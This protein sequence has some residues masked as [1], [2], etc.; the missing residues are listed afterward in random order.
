SP[1]FLDC[2]R[3]SKGPQMRNE[4]AAKKGRRV[5]SSDHRITRRP[6]FQ[7]PRCGVKS[8]PIFLLLPDP[9]PLTNLV[10]RQ[11]PHSLFVDHEEHTAIHSKKCRRS[12][13]LPE[14]ESANIRKEFS[15]FLASWL[16]A[17][18]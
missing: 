18:W 10:R 5:G 12:L 17:K 4:L 16:C 3:L 2:W 1:V 7:D 9:I 15:P 14:K 6:L 8:V 11:I 13:D